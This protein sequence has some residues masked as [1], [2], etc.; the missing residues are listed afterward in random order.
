MKSQAQIKSEITRK[1]YKTSY[2]LEIMTRDSFIF[3]IY[4]LVLQHT[5]LQEQEQIICKQ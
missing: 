4:F 5:G 3:I 1:I 2:I